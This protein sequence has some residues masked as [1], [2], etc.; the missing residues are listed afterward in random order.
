MCKTKTVILRGIQEV[1]DYRLDI[2]DRN[3]KGL[4]ELFSV[5]ES[6]TERAEAYNETEETDISAIKEKTHE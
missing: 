4:L 2:V 5:L 6:A 3:E 1:D